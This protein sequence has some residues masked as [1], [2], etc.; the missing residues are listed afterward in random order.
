[1]QLCQG[2]RRPT[3]NY[4]RLDPNASNL[5]ASPLLLAAAVTAAAAVV[6]R[7]SFSFPSHVAG[8]DLNLG[9]RWGRGSLRAG[10]QCVE[11]LRCFLELDIK[12]K[13]SFYLLRL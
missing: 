13:V 3:V 6:S 11:Q 4:K 1:M 8:I 7:A 5:E 9:E 12:K 2:K 10:D